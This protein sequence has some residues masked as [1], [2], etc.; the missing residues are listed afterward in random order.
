MNKRAITV[1]L[2][3][4]IGIAIFVAGVLALGGQ[5]N[6][7]TKAVQVKAIFDDVGGLQQGNNVWLSGVKVGIVK[8]INFISQS[9]VEVTMNIERKDQQYVKRDSKAKIGSDGLIGNKIVVLYG[10]SEQAPAVEEGT[11]LGVE[12]AISMDE[13]MA[14]LQEN[15]RNLLDITNDFKQ[16]SSGIANGQGTI[17]KLLKDETIGN[18][19]EAALASLRQTSVRANAMTKN[20]A[21]YTSKLQSEG[22]LS[23]DLITDTVIFSR[24]RATVGQIEE[25]SRN[26]NVIMEDL[27]RTT[28]SLQSTNTPVGVLLND[29]EVAGDIKQTLRNLQMGSQKLDEN[30]EALQH[31]FLLRGFFRK[32]ARAEE[33]G[34]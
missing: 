30:M 17:G 24:L 8:R 12:K 16:V 9:Q 22:S 1:G 7:F 26:A 33:R 5:N 14:T 28:Q 21:D 2:F 3:I 19:I 31:N 23:N 4:F 18:D 32:R 29:R 25:V 34:N 15:N 11:V 6:T 13:M 10:G 27:N 20:L